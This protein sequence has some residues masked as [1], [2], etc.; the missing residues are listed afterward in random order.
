MLHT[1]SATVVCAQGM[2]H[3]GLHAGTAQLELQEH[4]QLSW[5]RSGH[6]RVKRGP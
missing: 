6:G 2:L 1:Q 5:H 3:L 4:I